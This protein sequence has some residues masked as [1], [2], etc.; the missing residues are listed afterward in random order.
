MHVIIVD[1]GRT[2]MLKDKILAESL[3]CIRCGGCLNTCLYIVA[4]V[5]T[6]TTTPSRARLASP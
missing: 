5:A 6:A 1:N 3:K 2:E 4:V